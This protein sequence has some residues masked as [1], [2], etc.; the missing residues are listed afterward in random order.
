MKKYDLMHSVNARGTFLVSK[1]AIEHL[2][3]SQNPHILTLSPPL[4]IQGKWFK[5]HSAY[6]AAK[7]GMSM[8]TL[9]LSEE[10]R[11]VGIA[12]NSLWPLTTV[13]TAAMRMLGGDDASKSARKPEIMSDAAYAIF[14]KN[15]K[16]FTGNFCVDEELLRKEGIT[17][18]DQYAVEPGNKL[19][20][21][22][23]LP[24]RYYTGDLELMPMPDSSATKSASAGAPGSEAAKVFAAVQQKVTDELKKEI[25]AVMSFVISGDT[26]SV[27]ANSARPLK[28]ARGET[29]K[30]D[31]TIITDEETFLKMASGDVKAASAFMSGKLKIKGN[32]AIAM[33][34]EK[35]FQKLRA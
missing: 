1:Y 19:S 17:D 9:G 12:V 13:W 28:V 21:D 25:N 15:S 16:E 4:D 31:V 10:F 5:N 33:K 7:F 32:L 11:D 35:I 2:K 27:D 34:A 24:D 29:E 30:P 22:F 26:W 14:Q 3:K 6:T 23:F 18:F 8:Y 20:A